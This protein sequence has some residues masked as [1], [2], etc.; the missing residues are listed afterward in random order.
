MPGNFDETADA[1]PY[2]PPSPTKRRLAIAGVVVGGVVVVVLL[3]VLLLPEG[4]FGVPRTWAL[5]TACSGNLHDIG[6]ALHA[7]AG[8]YDGIF[9]P[10]LAPLHPNYFASNLGYECPS[11]RGKVGYIYV[12]GLR[13][14]DPLSCVLAFDRPGN[15]GK[16][17]GN[18]MFI[19]AR[20]QWMTEAELQKALAETRA[21]AKKKGRE[22]KLVG[23]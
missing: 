16:A 1:T 18:V 17:G 7:Y 6:M 13:T 19:G 11:R 2:L 20:A 10:E 15:H 3:L 12:A 21:E 9:P 5:R 8:D 23:E 22:I 14:A 4:A